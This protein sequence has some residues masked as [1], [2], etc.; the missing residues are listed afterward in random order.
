MKN[1]PYAEQY[2]M[3]MGSHFHELEGIPQEEPPQ[4]LPIEENVQ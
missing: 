2:Q 3:A 1:S 4:E